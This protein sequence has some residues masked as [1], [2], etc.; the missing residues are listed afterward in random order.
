M[1]P[2]CDNDPCPKSLVNRPCRLGNML[3]PLCHNMRRNHPRLIDH[4]RID[5]AYIESCGPFKFKPTNKTQHHL[6]ITEKKEILYYL[7]WL[8]KACFS[9]SRT[10]FYDYKAPALSVLDCLISHEIYN[11]FVPP[12]FGPRASSP[13]LFAKL[14]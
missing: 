1:W 8:S 3:R 12:T 6:L 14:A 9:I 7:N 5:A 10:L 13:M 2:E 4:R 11:A